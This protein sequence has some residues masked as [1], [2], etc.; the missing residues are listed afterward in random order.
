MLGIER[1]ERELIEINAML[2]HLS[3]QLDAIARLLR[4]LVDQDRVE[5]DAEG[6]AWD[7]GE[8]LTA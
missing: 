5:F 6:E 4:I 2:E 1:I 8:A 3:G 7:D